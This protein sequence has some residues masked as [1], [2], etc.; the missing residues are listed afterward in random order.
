VLPLLRLSRSRPPRG[1]A[2]ALLA[3]SVACAALGATGC[4]KKPTMHLNHAEVTGMQ[5]ALPPTVGVLMT[6]VVDVYNPNGYDVAVRAMRGQV[7]LAERYTMPLDFRPGGEGVW[8]P[9]DSTT[10]L[11]IP[12]SVPIDLALTLLREAYTSPSIGYRIIG[13]ADV[14]G[15]RTFKIESDDYSVDERGSIYRQQLEAVL[16]GGFR[17]GL[18]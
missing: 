2:A 7:I 8:L 17:M 18:P 10:Q 6:V 16:P 1:F 4:A 13:K 12:I 3:A 5:L 9:A 15:T 14:T 11:R